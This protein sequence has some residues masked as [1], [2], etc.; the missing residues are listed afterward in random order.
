MEYKSPKTI[1]ELCANH[2]GNPETA[3]ELIKMAKLCN[4][5]YVKFQKRVPEIC[6]PKEIQNQPHSCPMHSFGETYLQHRKFL[7]FN[8]ETHKE[9][10]KYCDEI[11][12]KYSCSVWDI[13]SAEEIISLNPDYIKVPSACNNNY[14]LIKTLLNKYNGDIHISL[15]MSTKEELNKLYGFLYDFRKRIVLYWTTSDYPVKFEDLFLL[16]ISQI[17]NSFTKGFSGHNLGIAVDIA[18]YTLGCSWFERHFTLD[19]TA[20]GNDHSASLERDG[21]Y[22]LVRD[23]KATH[24]ALQY[25][26]IDLTEG[27]IKNRKK[28]RVIP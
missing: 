2:Q 20:K 12:I 10:K 6:V 14:D 8:I 7:E 22:K 26:N 17:P 3:K 27:E 24:K 16:E 13:P 4:A 25:K 15:G 19:R 21:L 23:L 18:A 5:D 11:G 1:A 9:L 28:L